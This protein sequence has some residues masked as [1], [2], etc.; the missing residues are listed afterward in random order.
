MRAARL[1]A[2][3]SQ[4]EVARRADLSVS[5]VRLV[6]SGQ[7]DISLSRLLRWSTLFELPTAD[8]F[9]EPDR[10]EVLIVKPSQRL[11]VP[12][13]ER[14]VRFELLTPARNL[15]IEPGIFLL[16]PGSRMS[17]P[18][19]HKGEETAYVLNGIVQLSVGERTYRLRAADAAYYRS[20][21]P[22]SYA[23]MSTKDPAEV[24]VTTTHP[25]LH[26]RAAETKSG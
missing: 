2:G 17:R 25:A 22:H 7:S 24:L 13:G 23:N 10:S 18:L 21:V 12:T 6:E 5:F 14:G 1:A 19:V 3:I 15:E 8:L 16:A 9:A 20:D 11:K 4:A 26:A